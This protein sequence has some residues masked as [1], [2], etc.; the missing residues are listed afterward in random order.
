MDSADAPLV[1]GDLHAGGD[2]ERSGGCARTIQCEAGAD[3]GGSD[4]V[5]AADGA[6]FVCAAVCGEEPGQSQPTGRVI[7]LRAPEPARRINMSTASASSRIDQKI[8]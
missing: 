8:K 5:A 7:W 1:V 4:G 3:G 2:R 6:V